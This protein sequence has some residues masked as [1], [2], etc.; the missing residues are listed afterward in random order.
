MSKTLQIRDVPD[1]VHASVR[2]RAAQ[3]GISVSDYLLNLLS[4]LVSRPTMAEI[5]ERAQTLAR[6]G[7]GAS[8][9]DVQDA[10]REGRDR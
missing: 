2:A 9:A 1:D 5:V 6:A 4:E 7:G 8:R 3:A 10:V